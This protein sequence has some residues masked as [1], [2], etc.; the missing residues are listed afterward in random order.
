MLTN[1]RATLQ[2]RAFSTMTTSMMGEPASPLAELRRCCFLC[3]LRCCLGCCLGCCCLRYC[4]VQLLLL[5]TIRDCLKAC[6]E[7]SQRT[8][9]NSLFVCRSRRQSEPSGLSRPPGSR[10]SLRVCS[11]TDATLGAPAGSP[12]RERASLGDASRRLRER[13]SPPSHV[14]PDALVPPIRYAC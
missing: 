2:A 5:L 3:C 14:L 8:R 12:R 4:I 13:S 7:V 6:G 10:E 1:L 11:C 9:R